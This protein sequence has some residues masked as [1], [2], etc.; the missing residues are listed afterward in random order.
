MFFLTV[1]F[2]ILLSSLYLGRI[3]AMILLPKAYYCMS[4]HGKPWSHYKDHMLCS[5]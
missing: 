1:S 4:P 3:T 2:R 5:I